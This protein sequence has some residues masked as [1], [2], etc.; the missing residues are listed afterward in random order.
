M[1][2]GLAKYLASLH[3]NYLTAAAK[4]RFHDDFVAIAHVYVANGPAMRSLLSEEQY[5]ALPSDVT[6]YF[7][8]D[9]ATFQR[10]MRNADFGTLL[11]LITGEGID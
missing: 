11:E 5:G 4:K 2:T 8:M 1:Y 9:E 7:D 10:L 6:A 3:G